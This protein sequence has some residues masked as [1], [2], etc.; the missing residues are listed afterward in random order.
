MKARLI[1]TTHLLIKVIVFVGLFLAFT[2]WILTCNGTSPLLLIPVEKYIELQNYFG[3]TCCESAADFDA[4]L[5]MIIAL[6]LTAVTFW[7]GLR[8]MRFIQNTQNN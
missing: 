2:R 5:S 3:V 7:L 4:N 1:A 6:P 8:C